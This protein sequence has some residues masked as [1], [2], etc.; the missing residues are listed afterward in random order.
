MSWAISRCSVIM[1]SAQLQ[2][3]RI[4]INNGFNRKNALGQSQKCPGQSQDPETG[5]AVSE[6]GK[7]SWP[8]SR[9]PKILK[10]PNH[11]EMVGPSTISRWLGRFRILKMPIGNLE[12]ALN[13]ENARNINTRIYY[14]IIRRRRSGLAGAGLSLYACLIS[15]FNIVNIV[16]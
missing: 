12:I 1:F 16:I 9:L 6:S 10:R 5:W 3:R 4:C 14:M 2:Q 13:P 8:I 11:L 15:Y 7:R